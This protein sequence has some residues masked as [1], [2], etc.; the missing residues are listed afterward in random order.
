MAE[1]LPFKGNQYLKGNLQNPSEAVKIVCLYLVFLAVLATPNW[2]FSNALTITSSR[3]SSTS[4]KISRPSSTSAEI[5]KKSTR[6]RKL[7]TTENTGYAFLI[8]SP[9][10]VNAVSSDSDCDEKE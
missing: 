3:P 8:W 1:R 6:P 9:E 7:S 2:T 5:S 10:V 4:T